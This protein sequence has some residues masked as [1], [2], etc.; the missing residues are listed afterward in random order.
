MSAQW[1]PAHSPP[2]A[3]DAKDANSVSKAR[4]R[5]RRWGGANGETGG[6]RAGILASLSPYGRG[7]IRRVT[8]RGVDN[9]LVI[10]LV[11]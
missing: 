11:L 1:R 6:A 7:V 4:E 5:K 8:Y 2:A 9:P 3:Q 10:C